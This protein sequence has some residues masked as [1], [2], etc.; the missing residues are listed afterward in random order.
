MRI[1]INILIIL[2]IINQNI[3]IAKDDIMI[4]K[5]KDH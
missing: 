3:A 4:L 5:L 1:L 2:F